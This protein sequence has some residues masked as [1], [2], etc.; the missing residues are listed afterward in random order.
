MSKT[1]KFT[2]DLPEEFLDIIALSPTE[3]SVQI[4][5]SFVMQ[6]LRE[7]KISQGK[8]AELLGVRRWDLPKLLPKYEIPAIM[9]SPEELEQDRQNLESAL[10]K[11]LDLGDREG[12][13]EVGVA[14]DLA[15]IREKVYKTKIAPKLIGARKKKSA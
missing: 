11:F 2:I 14:R 7:V 9:M 1:M 6:L 15:R 8:T 4:R 3:V 13:S 5:E 10:G 12:V